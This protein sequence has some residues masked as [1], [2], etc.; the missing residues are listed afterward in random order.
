MGGPGSGR[1][2]DEPL[3]PIEARKL[4]RGLNLDTEADLKEFLRRAEVL[5]LVGKM[6]IRFF[7]ELRE[8]IGERRMLLVGAGLA[9]REKRVIQAA[10]EIKAARA[11]GRK[12]RDAGPP[13]DDLSAPPRGNGCAGTGH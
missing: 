5:M 8:S 6:P 11:G 13:D 7:R 10:E 1:Q 2:P 12:L 4:Y 9:N 3:D